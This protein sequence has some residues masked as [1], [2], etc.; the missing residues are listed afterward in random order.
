VVLWANIRTDATEET[1]IGARGGI[2]V[3]PIPGLDDVF[4]KATSGLVD[5]TG[6]RGFQAQRVP[7]F[8]GKIGNV[9][10]KGSVE[11]ALTKPSFDILRGEYLSTPDLMWGFKIEAKPCETLGASLLYSYYSPMHPWQPRI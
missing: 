3:W 2:L 8:S 7:G 9:K 6:P 5:F 11:F 4:L 1:T 10:G